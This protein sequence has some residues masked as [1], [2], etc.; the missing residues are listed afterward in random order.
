MK[1]QKIFLTGK[2]FC[3][4]VR[5]GSGRL[6][7]NPTIRVMEALGVV[8]PVK[9]TVGWRSYTEQDVA[10]AIRWMRANPPRPRGRPPLSAPGVVERP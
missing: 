9:N 1:G 10:R 2:V 7:N 8:Q 4:R 6:P 3:Q 5:A